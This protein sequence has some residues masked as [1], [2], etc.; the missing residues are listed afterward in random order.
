MDRNGIPHTT[1]DETVMVSLRSTSGVNDNRSGMNMDYYDLPS[2]S[3]NPD[4]TRE[5]LKYE[6]DAL[7]LMPERAVEK[8]SIGYDPALDYE[9]QLAEDSAATSREKKSK[10]E[11]KKGSKSAEKHQQLKPN[12]RS[13]DKKFVGK[14]KPSTLEDARAR[15]EKL[16]SFKADLQKMKKEQVK[17]YICHFCMNIIYCHS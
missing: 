11:A 16:R 6:P 3:Q 5:L 1:N 14:G 13:L 8:R 9:M 12:Q 2:S 15:A 4:R 7:S 17:Y 10:T